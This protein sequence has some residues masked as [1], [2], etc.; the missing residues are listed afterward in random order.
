MYFEKCTKVM[1]FAKQTA[2]E[3]WILS[4]VGYKNQ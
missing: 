2:Q 1:L 3:K 4:S